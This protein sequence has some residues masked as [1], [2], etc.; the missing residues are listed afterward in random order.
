MKKL[1][2]V[3]RAEMILSEEDMKDLITPIDKL[4]EACEELLGKAYI[5]VSYNEDT[6]P[7]HT[8]K[9]VK[10]GDVYRWKLINYREP[11]ALAAPTNLWANSFRDANT[12]R[13]TV[14]VHWRDPDDT[15]DAH[16]KYTVLV[17]KKG[18]APTSIYDGEVVGYSSV[19]N[20][21]SGKRGMADSIDSDVVDDSDIIDIDDGAPV[22][23]PVEEQ[24]FYNV[25][26]VT[27]FDV[28]SFNPDAACGPL[29]T[30]KKF[31]EL[32]RLGI[33]N[34]ALD[35]GDTVEVVHKDF[36]KIYFQVVAFNNARLR[37][38]DTGLPYTPNSVTFMSCD[39][40]FRGSF[41]HKELL[42]AQ[43]TD[44]NWVPGKAYYDG[45]THQVIP[46]S[47][48]VRS[49]E[50]YNAT[51]PGKAC[52]ANPCADAAEVG[53]NAWDTSN[54]RQWLN[55]LEGIDWFIAKNIWDR[56]SDDYAHHGCYS[57]KDTNGTIHKLS[58]FLG[59]LPEDLREVLATNIT[60]TSVPAWRGEQTPDYYETDD[61]IFLPSYVELFGI[62][63]AFP[64]GVSRQE[65]S[66]FDIYLKKKTNTR[67]KLMLD[68][69][70]TTGYGSEA[71]ADGKCKDPADCLASWYMRTPV[72][73]IDV[74]RGGSPIDCVEIVTAKNRRYD[75]Q[76]ELGED[77]GAGRQSYEPAGDK[78]S[79]L[80]SCR[81][82]R[83]NFFTPVGYTVT[84]CNNTAAG[85]VPC[86]VVA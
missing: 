4:P 62:D 29:L 38:H 59:G 25:F 11:N 86:F 43:T 47:D 1:S 36:G 39:V 72:R 19:R 44:A 53:C 52:E 75:V 35:L 74:E 63:R 84:Y 5:I 6:F 9:C 28:V 13:A 50:E 69:F 85:F 21:Y 51:H 73:M 23:I 58:G 79:T 68:G 10:Q 57:W 37:N 76:H 42:L 46:D 20:Q 41:D 18:S 49:L 14:F 54:A 70:D 12:G 83:S 78:T 80:D 34:Y 30:W 77:G 64:E 15:E 65:G 22:P 56:Y 7:A 33:A 31:Q 82:S 32:V 17:K 26:A 67:M 8:Y 24:Y 55:S 61:I 3:E 40:L 16:W 66:Q 71:G 60:R 45:N 27:I 2:D 81:D 48:K